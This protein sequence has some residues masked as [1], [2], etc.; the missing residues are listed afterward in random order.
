[1]LYLVIAFVAVFAAGNGS[2]WLIHSWKT[3]KEIANIQAEKQSLINT[4]SALYAANN[5]CANDINTVQKGFEEIF[6]ANEARAKGAAEAITKAQEQTAIHK[7]TARA[8][9]FAPVNPKESWCAAIEREQIEYVRAR[10][11]ADTD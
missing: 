1:M 2:G 5:K 9:K 3:G 6:R 10:H 7:Q 11:A 4:N 8:I